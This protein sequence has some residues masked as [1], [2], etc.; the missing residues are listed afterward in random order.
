[1]NSLDKAR[2][3]EKEKSYSKRGTTVVSCDAA[4]RLDE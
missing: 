3:Y 1:M 2:K 4:G